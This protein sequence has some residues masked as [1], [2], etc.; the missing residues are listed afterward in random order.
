MFWVTCCTP[1]LPSRR[2]LRSK[3]TAATS[4]MR[5]PPKDSNGVR[6]QQPD[7]GDDADHEQQGR[8]LQVAQGVRVDGRRRDLAD[9]IG[10]LLGEALLDLEQNP[11]FVFGERHRRHDRTAEP[12]QQRAWACFPARG[13]SRSGPHCWSPRRFAWIPSSRRVTAGAMASAPNR[14]RMRSIVRSASGPVGGVPEGELLGPAVRQ[15]ADADPDQ[16]DTHRHVDRGQQ[17]L[18]RPGDDPTGVGDVGQCGRAGDGAEVPEADLQDHGAPGEAVGPQAAT[19]GVGQAGQLAGQGGRVVVIGGEGLLVADG[20]DALVRDHRSVI[21][22]VRQRVEVPAAGVAD[23]GHEG[24]Q[25]QRGEV[26]DRRHA[27][28]VEALVGLGPDPPEGPHRERVEER[29]LAA[30]RHHDDAAARSDTVE[31]GDRLGRLGGELGQE[32]RR[33]DA[34]RAGQPLLVQYGVPDLQPRSPARCPTAAG[35]R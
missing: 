1:A 19:D 20:L 31:R 9:E 27:E 17:G 7:H 35:T 29:Q 28:A 13:L 24:G 21:D 33:G 2:A 32:L 18:G 23:R 12:R 3:S 8:Q 25:G 34:H 30:D 14:S 26:P 15:A 22:P 6:P 5:K 16:A 10:I 4:M 11:L